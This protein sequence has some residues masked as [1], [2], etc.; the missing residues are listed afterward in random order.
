MRDANPLVILYLQAFFSLYLERS[1]TNRCFGHKFL[2]DSDLLE[3]LKA[4][5][6]E[7]THLFEDQE[8]TGSFNYVPILKAFLV[9]IQDE[10][11][12]NFDLKQLTLD[13]TVLRSRLEGCVYGNVFSCRTGWWT[14]FI[15]VESY[16][17][18]MEIVRTMSV[19]PESQEPVTFQLQENAMPLALP[20]L[21][22]PMIPTFESLSSNEARKILQTETALL[23]K[24]AKSFS[25]VTQKLVDLDTDLIKDLRLMYKTV[26]KRGTQVKTCSAKCAGVVVEFDYTERML[27]HE[28]LEFVQRNRQTSDALYDSDPVDVLVCLAA[29]RIFRILEYLGDKKQLVNAEDF[30]DEFY[31]IIELMQDDIDNYPPARIVLHQLAQELG[32]MFVY[33]KE[34]EADR[35]FDKLSAGH[36]IAVLAPAFNPA[37]SSDKFLHYYKTLSDRVSGKYASLLFSKFD[38][39]DWLTRLNPSTQEK[40]EMI[41]AILVACE[42]FKNEEADFEIHASLLRGLVAC[43]HGEQS[44][45]TLEAIM[46]KILSSEI[47]VIVFKYSW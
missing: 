10:R 16:A 44:R 47:S 12:V 29:L 19:Q 34:G 35:I 24:K 46:P 3:K 40:N 31:S 28:A 26:T 13:E 39:N 33:S 23:S 20:I 30:K 21:R 38:L 37:S 22:N 2:Q 36:N 11:L 15:H 9:W 41:Q 7:M 43:S 42:K 5:L 27:D 4:Y 25:L 8:Q 45:L 32:E 18:S 6:L 17:Y 1:S 14:E